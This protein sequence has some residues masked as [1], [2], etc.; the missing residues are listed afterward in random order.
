MK[1]I[2][3]GGC[4]WED[5]A[6]FEQSYGVKFPPDY[7]E[8]LVKYNGGETLDTHFYYSRR[9]SSDIEYFYG[10]GDV[11]FS[12]QKDTFPEEIELP[13]LLE[14]GLF[15]IGE[16]VF[17][18]Y[19]L[20]RVRSKKQAGLF[21]WIKSFGKDPSGS[22]YFC[23]HDEGFEKHKLTNSFKAFIEKC[24]SEEVDINEYTTPIAE[25]EADLI[26][27][28]YG[29]NIDD[30]L[31]KSWQEEIDRYTGAVLEEVVLS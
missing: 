26:S 8:F 28:G 9:L 17:G 3:Q 10:I 18:D 23:I 7:A 4:T 21:Q 11:E 15:P 24:E 5:V 22:V 13:E 19:I 14:Q 16:N 30:F 6:E 29:A 25:R 2:K 20:M 12:V 27:R 1:I 31:R